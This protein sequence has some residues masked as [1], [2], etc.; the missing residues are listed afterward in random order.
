MANI[1]DAARRSGKPWSECHPSGSPG[2][3]SQVPPRCARTASLCF[4]TDR[5]SPCSGLLSWGDKRSSGLT[6]LKPRAPTA[7]VTADVPLRCMPRMT[8]HGPLT[9]SLI[10]SSQ[11]EYVRPGEGFAKHAATW[12]Q[13]AHCGA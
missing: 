9:A 3:A 6:R 11:M 7:F 13:M 2:G 1:F 5:L 12:A 10:R 4:K 8:T